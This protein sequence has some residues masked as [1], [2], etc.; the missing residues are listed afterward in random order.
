MAQ[1]NGIIL[2]NAMT[3][4]NKLIQSGTNPRSAM[5][6]VSQ[7]Y[8]S[9]LSLY[10]LREGEWIRVITTNPLAP[11]GSV[12]VNPEALNDLWKTGLHCGEGNNPPIFR[13]QSIFLKS[14]FP[15]GSPTILVAGLNQLVTTGTPVVARSLDLTP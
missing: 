9:G 5:R 15:N 11:L 2:L 12:L 13:G 10:L 6:Y 3:T 7:K 14:N 4:L 8:G 1:N